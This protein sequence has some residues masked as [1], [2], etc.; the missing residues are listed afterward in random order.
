MTN[1]T[2]DPFPLVSVIVRSMNRPTLQNALAS[3]GAQ[4]YPNIEVILVNAIGSVHQH[5]GDVS[6]SFPIRF[7]SPG[8]PLGRS[9]AANI[10]LKNALGQYLVFLDDD[11]WFE[12]DHIEILMNA[13]KSNPTCKVAYTGT[14]CVDGNGTPLH[15]QFDASFDAV[16][17]LSG[18][19]IPIHAVLFSRTLIDLGCY[20]DE[21]L[22][23]YEDW[24]FWIQLSQHVDFL[25]VKG[26]SAVYRITTQSGFGLNATPQ[27]KTRSSLLVYS[28][29]IHRLKES[30]LS[31]L[32]QA[33]SDAFS[34]EN[35]LCNLKAKLNQT[36]FDHDLEI[37][38]LNQALS[39][40]ELEIIRLNQ[41][42]SDHEL[43]INKLKSTLVI[44]QK[45][46]SWRVTKPLRLLRQHTYWFAR[47]I[48]LAYERGI[49]NRAK[50][51]LTKLLAQRSSQKVTDSYPM[52]SNKFDTPNSEDSQKLSL[53]TPE[54][55]LIFIV[56]RFDE[57][58]EKYAVEVALHLI[59]SVGQ[60]WLANFIFDSNCDAKKITYRIQRATKDDPRISFNVFPTNS[61]IDFILW[62]EGGALIREHALRI[63]TDALRSKPNALVA[64]SDEDQINSSGLIFNPW[65]K[66]QFSP[67]L[68]QQDVLLGRAIVFRSNNA[69][70]RSFADTL[71]FSNDVMEFIRNYALQAGE[72]QVVHIPH[73]LFHDAMPVRAARPI[74]FPA[75]KILPVVSIIIPTRD[76]WDLLGACLKSLKS[77]DWPTECIDILVIDNG[78]T[79]PLCL[80]GMA[81]AQSQ[82]LIRVIRD[83]Q[84]FNWSRLNNLG[85]S[86]SEGEVL[87]FLNNDTEVLDR[88]WLKKLCALAL[89]HNTGAVGC[90]LL[91]PDQT[92]QH[93]GV[94]AGI[95]GVA[96]HAHLLLQANEGGYRNLANITHE[97]S[98]VT[99]ACLAVTRSNFDSVG[100]FNESLRVAFSDTIFCFDLHTR[101]KRN[102]YVSDPLFVHHES[103]SRGY[104]DTPEKLL[105]NRTEARQTWSI[106]PTLMRND[107]FYS[108]NLSLLSPYL[109]SPAPRRRSSWDDH[110]QRPLRVMMLSITHAIGHG[111]AV[112]MA[113]Q[114]KALV[115][116]G[117][118]VLVAG[119]VGSRD[120]AYPGCERIEID[121]PLSAA[122]IAAKRSVDLIIAETPPF[123]SVAR[124]TGSHPPVLAID[125]GEPPAEWFPDAES[126]RSV[127]QEKDQ[128]LMMAHTVMAISSAVQAESRTPVH[129]ILP[130]GNSH[131]GQW[132]E[133]TNLR[134][135]RVRLERGWEGKFVV[136]NVCRFHRSERH[137]KGVNTYA[138]VLNKLS[139]L[140]PNLFKKTSF[141][142]CGKGL[143]HEVIEMKKLGFFVAAN[144]SDEE[145][146]DLYCAAD[147]YANFSKWEGYNLGIG[148]ALALGLPS[149]ASDIPAHR[150]FGID[151]T[152]EPEN[153][154]IWLIKVAAE[155]NVRKPILWKWENILPQLIEIT[156]S[157]CGRTKIA[158]V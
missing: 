15:N 10:G 33:V 55:S 132:N 138:D 71:S 31:S 75:P 46:I 153:A 158:G 61:L 83:D 144:V 12:H 24:D 124:W 82:H 128:S 36:F 96:G 109:L 50:A 92:V 104:D 79:D 148:Q 116:Q 90:K 102:V 94:I 120:F 48:K 60:H 139:T 54:N 41:A 18:N 42:Q 2:F 66:P 84:Q 37:K 149:I 17:L 1:I 123:F 52:W 23:V 155:Q 91:Y 8:T 99:G 40:H 130:N 30:Q 111:V 14:K 110:T 51:L 68:I 147:A 95:Q 106:H 19:F 88:E 100:G 73:V 77:T 89:M 32:M 141:V 7:I 34:R 63:F 81:D 137:Y 117:Y 21:S 103:K 20:F 70:L 47:Q 13:F 59:A 157:I 78:S 101:G 35:E 146:I 53:S 150:N 131:L 64:Y 4:S 26:L 154:A 93:G 45:T 67:L 112:V 5:Q 74:T 58:T 135:Q 108:P 125:H 151:V 107:P 87:V 38:R 143:P 86:K 115:Q 113:L 6:W 49:L 25:K 27:V 97:V 140:D 69:T 129:G 80:K 142:L 118:E 9:N 85:A 44:M 57:S 28:K 121:D 39:D 127:L 119:P 133:Q 152:N 11:D 29:W 3:I 145:M 114:A 98:A 62:I 134:R 136:L 76:R 72:D 56:A 156:D 43:E 122:I 65:F 16:K 126:R 22:D 105:L